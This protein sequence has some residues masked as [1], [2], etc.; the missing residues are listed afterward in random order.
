MSARF[1]SLASQQRQWSWWNDVG[2]AAILGRRTVIALPNI[3][4]LA[5]L[6]AVIALIGLVGWCGSKVSDAW[7]SSTHHVAEIQQLDVQSDGGRNAAEKSPPPVSGPRLQEWRQVEDFEQPLAQLES[8]FW[9]PQDTVSLRQLIRETPLVR[10][11]RVLE[12]GCGTGLISLCCLQAGAAHVVATDVNPAAIH[13]V[14]YNADVLGLSA[15]LETRLV[16]LDAVEAF[17]VIGDAEQ[18]DL[19]ISNPPW[20]DDKPISMHDYALYDEG[21][22]LLRSLLSE[23]DKH[24][25]PGGRC[26]LAYGCVEAIRQVH[27]LAPKYDLEVRVLDER[28]FDDL[29][30]QFLPG[31]LLEV[32]PNREQK[33]EADADA[34]S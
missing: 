2:P 25:S 23:L 11:R 26:L 17:S 20:E 10:G 27:E 4:S 32:R 5:L 15:Q 22:V 8:V 7:R 12:I 3:R 28:D 14:Q 31:M 6:A 13:N 24:L 29:P 18:F 16:P 34:T 1:P 30:N 19:I 21:F 33:G 9:E